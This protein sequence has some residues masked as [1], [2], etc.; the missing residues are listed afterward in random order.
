MHNKDYLGGLRILECD[1]EAVPFCA[2]SLQENLMLLGKD[3]I[4]LPPLLC[5]NYSHCYSQ[6]HKVVISRRLSYR[7]RRIEYVISKTWTFIVP[8]KSQDSS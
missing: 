6:R 2:N 7:A 5:E 4:A 8:P 3:L 1:T